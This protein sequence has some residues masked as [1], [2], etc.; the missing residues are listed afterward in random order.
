MRM[1]SVPSDQREKDYGP[2]LAVREIVT[3]H[4]SLDIHSHQRRM[5]SVSLSCSPHC[6]R[7][8]QRG[9]LPQRVDCT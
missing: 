1:C 5:K 2:W 8:E 4:L 3:G 6:Y 9:W 7:Q